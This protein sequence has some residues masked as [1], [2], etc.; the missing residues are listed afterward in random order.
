MVSSIA[1]IDYDS[2][3]HQ[4]AQRILTLFNERETRDELGLGAI[5]DAIADTLF[6]G[7]STIQTRLRYMLFLPWVFLELERRGT[8]AERMSK[9]ARKAQLRLAEYLNENCPDEIGNIGGDAGKGLKRL[10]SDVY[11]TGLGTWGIRLFPGT[12]GQYR[13][14]LDHIYRRRKRN[15]QRR[16][17]A[18]DEGD[19]VGG[20]WEQAATTWHPGIPEPPQGFP[21]TADFRLR[22]EEAHYLQERVRHACPD[23]LLADLLSEPMAVQI[24]EP[25]DHP[26]IADFRPNHRRL[27]DHAHNFA[28]VAQGAALLYNILLAELQGS[29]ELVARHRETAGRWADRV[30]ARLDELIGW[31]DQL[32]KF[33]LEVTDRG[34]EI[35]PQTISFVTRWIPELLQHRHGVVDAPRARRLIRDREIEKKRAN[36]RFTNKRVL[37]Q[38]GGSSGLQLFTYR[39][40]V[41]QSYVEDTARALGR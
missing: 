27:L 4:R 13:R 6:P 17:T 9:R 23:S 5:R 12:E 38:W 7:T 25:W 26:G 20:L 40:G 28:L 18:A 3:A 36:S 39:W 1:W 11:W 30:D 8:S 41:V 22:R 14:A 16:S 35:G 10:P 29:E 21:E 34:H 2:E 32:D 33:W 31:A 19:D 37:D 15:T 24:T